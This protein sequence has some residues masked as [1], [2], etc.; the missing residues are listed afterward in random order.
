MGF[1]KNTCEV[2]V[3][4]GEVNLGHGSPSALVDGATK[5]KFTVNHLCYFMFKPFEA[6]VVQASSSSFNLLFADFGRQALSGVVATAE[7][8]SSISSSASLS[9]V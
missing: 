7:C 8:C 2:K 6:K 5:Y 1:A 9:S 3:V 4:G